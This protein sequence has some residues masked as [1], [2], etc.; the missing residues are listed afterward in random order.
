VLW[1]AV[2][3]VATLSL[4][5]VRVALAHFQREALLGKEFDILNI[6][7]IAK[8]FFRAFRGQAIS[9]GGW[10]KGVYVSLIKQKLSIL[11]TIIIGVVALGLSYSW[12]V[13]GAAAQ[14]TDQM[15]SDGLSGIFKEVIEIPEQGLSFPYIFW[16]NTRAIAIISFLGLFSFGILGEVLY[17][18]NMGVIGAF[19]GLSTASGYAPLPMVIYGI[20]PHGIFEVPALII[21]S[22]SILHIGVTLV[23]PA[24]QKTLGETIIE[25]LAEWLRI[26]LG[27]V[28]P[29]II[30]AAVVETWIT[31]FLLLSM[32]K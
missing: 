10:F 25:N 29:L 4:L 8:T 31:P 5:L 26:N 23:T 32:A 27:I 6:R 14:W 9:V 12:A 30:I 24:V 13:S 22:A 11:V 16:H 15:S 2:V 19:L 21:S 17:A 1:L 28:L 20:L 18:L 3:A 7:W